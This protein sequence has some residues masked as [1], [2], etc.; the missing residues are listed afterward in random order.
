MRLIFAS[1]RCALR[2]LP[3][4]LVLALS[5]APSFAVSGKYKDVCASGCTYSDV[6]TALNSITD[7]SATNVYTVFV[8]AGVLTSD[9]AISFGGKSYINLEGRGIGSSILRASATWFANA[10]SAGSGIL[11]DL[12]GSTN[13]TVRGITV[14]AKTNDDGTHPTSSTYTAIQTDNADKLVFDSMEALAT[15]NGI[16]DHANS[17]THKIDVRN[18]Q[19][20]GALYG[21]YVVTGAA[22]HVF[23]SDIRGIYTG[24]SESAPATGQGAL[25]V[26]GTDPTSIDVWGSHLHGEFAATTGACQ[27]AAVRSAQNAGSLTI[28]GST[29]HA[30]ISGTPTG[31]PSAYAFRLEAINAG[32]AHLVGSELI[33]E[34]GTLSSGYIGGIGYVSGT[35]GLAVVLDNTSITDVGGTGGTHRGDIVFGSPLGTSSQPKI[36]TSTLHSSQPAPQKG[37]ATLA[38]GTATVT[39]SPAQADTF[40][41]VVLTSSTTETLTVGSKTTTSF[42][43]TSSNGSSTAKV[44]YIVLR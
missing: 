27:I 12:S 20:R 14:D 22:W 44:D 1:N 34:T 10:G 31:T 39:L 35:S 17:T 37:T 33:Y 28:I 6:Q 19:I 38:S 7:S 11:L 8:D 15:T 23:S 25:V 43:I 16:W 36:R 42:T 9:T 26:S 30:K 29:V 2:F 21:I 13:V 5:V 18:C 32:T 4:L 24:V 40:Y 3:V 41:Y